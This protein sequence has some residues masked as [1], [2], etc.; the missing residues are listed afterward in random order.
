MEL[1]AANRAEAELL[2]DLDAELMAE[3]TAFGTCRP[4]F[5]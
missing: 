5:W 4:R 1:E 3:A 2:E